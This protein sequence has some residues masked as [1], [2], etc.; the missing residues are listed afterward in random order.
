MAVMALRELLTS[1]TGFDRPSQES[2]KANTPYVSAH[3]ISEIVTT[4]QEDP[5]EV[6]L[7]RG[8]RSN[9]RADITITEI[10]SWIQDFRDN[11]ESSGHSSALRSGVTAEQVVNDLSALARFLGHHR[12]VTETEVQTV[13]FS[14]WVP[15]LG[16]GQLSVFA[17]S[18]PALAV[19]PDVFS[20]QTVSRWLAGEVPD[21]LILEWMFIHYKHLPFLLTPQDVL[22]VWFLAK[23]DRLST[24]VDVCATGDTPEANSYQAKV[25]VDA[26]DLLAVATSDAR[27]GVQLLLRSHDYTADELNSDRVRAAL[28]RVAV[29]QQGTVSQVMRSYEFALN[30]HL[31]E[32]RSSISELEKLVASGNWLPYEVR[33]LSLGQAHSICRSAGLP[34]GRVSPVVAN[35]VRDAVRSLNLGHRVTEWLT[36]DG[37]KYANA[38]WC[39]EFLAALHKRG[40]HDITWADELARLVTP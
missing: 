2:V 6:E 27:R 8:Y 23:G 26:W 38:G 7:L 16:S 33:D 1:Y 39:E 22:A 10:R 28:S 34:M 18:S 5:D 11:P 36:I 25:M 35:R 15:E 19:V 12:G 13:K 14:R 20:S 24:L 17:S 37:I 40:R 4:P 32:W 30:G 3:G 9:Y 31:G 29:L 21:T